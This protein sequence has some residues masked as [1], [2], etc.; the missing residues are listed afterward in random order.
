M[1]RYVAEHTTIRKPGARK[2]S[3]RPKALKERGPEW[4]ELGKISD[5]QLAEKVGCARQNVTRV[6]QRLGI[7]SARDRAIF[8]RMKAALK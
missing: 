4:D 8:E 7:P 2:G 6:R 5:A 1:T 3:L